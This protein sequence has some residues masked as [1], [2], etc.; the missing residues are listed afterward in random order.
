[1]MKKIS[2]KLKSKP[3]AISPEYRVEYK[4]C[5]LVIILYFS[6]RKNKA[7][8]NKINYIMNSLSTHISMENI[9]FLKSAV[10]NYSDLD[11]T[12]NKVI[13][14]AIIDDIVKVEDGEVILLD[15]GMELVEFIIN[16]SLFDEEVKLLKN[17]KK[18]FISEN[19]LK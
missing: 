16:N 18:D 14:L 15:K 19:R 4:V 10:N 2:V 6:C 7:S 17:K 11:K 5:M 12:L 1:M 9:S 8:I 13:N 3:I